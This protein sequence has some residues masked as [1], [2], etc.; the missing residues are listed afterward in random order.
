MRSSKCIFFYI[1]F[2]L[3]GRGRGRG[4]GRREDQRTDSVAA[5]E[6]QEEGVMR[7]SQ[8]IVVRVVGAG[9]LRR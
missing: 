5:Q 2:L 4:R 8:V 9:K 7:G 3:R 1:T 6:T